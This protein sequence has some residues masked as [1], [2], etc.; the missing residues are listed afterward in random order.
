M[1]STSPSKPR[2]SITWKGHHFTLEE[3]PLVELTSLG[4][5]AYGQQALQFCQDWLQGQEVFPIHT[6]G[7]TGKPKEIKIH[8]EQMDASAQATL[9]F[10]GLQAGARALVCIPTQYIGGRMMLVR[11]LLGG[12]HLHVIPPQSNP[13]AEFLR[14]LSPE[15]LPSY[16]F[17]ALVPL[18]LQTL[19]EQEAHVIRS[20]E[21]AQAIIVGG[22]PVSAPLWAKLQKLK[23]PVYSTYGMT[24]TVSHIALRALNGSQASTSF[25]LLPGNEIQVDDR[26]CLAVRG[27][28][29]LGQWIQTNDR[30]RLK[31]QDAFEWLGRVDHVINSGGIK[32]LVEPLEQKM[33]EVFTTIVPRTDYFIA[34]QKDERLGEKVILLIEHPGLDVK[35]ELLLKNQLA[36][37]LNKYEIP[38]K[39]IAVEEFARTETGK[40]RRKHTLDS[41]HNS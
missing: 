36:K 39:I 10:L 20:L 11:G 33:A 19:L 21:K 24:E 1:K 13:Y 38:K 29:T 6:S 26:Q 17:W 15:E 32:V 3:L 34:S 4:I 9:R 41:L 27:A 31:A 8:R 7:S 14:S 35:T 12:L 23:A 30:V 22:A 40:V 18:Q 37:T 28:V 5:D 2:G 16:D 25:Q